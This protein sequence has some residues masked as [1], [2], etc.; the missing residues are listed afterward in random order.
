MAPEEHPVLQTEVPMNP[1][2]NREFMMQNMFETFNV[3]GYMAVIQGVL[4][5]H[6]CGRV[7]GASLDIGDGVCNATAVFEGYALP[8]SKMR[9]DVTGRDLTEYLMKILSERGYDFVN[10]SEREIF[11]DIKEKLCYTSFDFDADMETA[12]STSTIDRTYE[13]PDGSTITIG[14]ERFRCAEAL[15]QPEFLGHES[16]GI[17]EGFY[18]SVVKCPQEIHQSLYSSIVLSGGTTMFPGFPERFEK[19]LIRLAP[20]IKIVAPPERKDTVWIGGSILASLPTTLNRWV[21][22]EQ[23]DEYGPS[24]VHRKCF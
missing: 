10:H 21:L 18:K 23:Y 22:K 3:P 7:T 24:L 2:A 19:E 4:A 6:A 5:V 20:G 13:M 17:H 1:R 14:N 16:C 15:F 11:R 9:L 12:A 8:Y